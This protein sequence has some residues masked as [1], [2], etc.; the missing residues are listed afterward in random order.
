[1]SAD[2]LTRIDEYLATPFVVSESALDE[3]LVESRSARIPPIQISPTQ[4]KLLQ[5]PGARATHPIALGARLARWVQHNPGWAGIASS[6]AVGD[7][8]AE[9]PLTLEWEDPMNDRIA[10]EPRVRSPPSRRSAVTA[11]TAWAASSWMTIDDG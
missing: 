7:S 10:F 2:P 6:C 11:A 1:M 9:P 5:I 3:A 8:G 4:G